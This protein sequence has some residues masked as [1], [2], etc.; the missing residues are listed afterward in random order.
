MKHLLSLSLLFAAVSL[1]AGESAPTEMQLFEYVSWEDLVSQSARKTIA[2]ALDTDAARAAY[3]ELLKE[4]RALE[5]QLEEAGIPFDRAGAVRFYMSGV[6][7][8]DPQVYSEL[9]KRIE[10]M[11]KKM[12]PDLPPGRFPDAGQREKRT[13]FLASVQ[14]DWDWLEAHSAFP[15]KAPWNTE[16]MLVSQHFRDVSLNRTLVHIWKMRIQEKAAS[17]DVS[18]ALEDFRKSRVMMDLDGFLISGLLAVSC[19][20]VRLTALSELLSRTELTPEQLEKL[21]AEL[22]EEEALL[23]R[24]WLRAWIQESACG[25]D[26]IESFIQGTVE[27]LAKYRTSEGRMP[28]LFAIPWTREW[29]FLAKRNLRIIDKVRQQEDFRPFAPDEFPKYFLLSR[30]MLDFDFDGANAI[31]FN[32]IAQIRAARTALRH[33]GLKSAEIP[34]DPFTGEPFHVREGE[35]RE[36]GHMVRGIRFYSAGRDGKYSDGTCMKS[37]LGGRKTDDRGFDLV[38]AEVPD[39]PENGDNASLSGGSQK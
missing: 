14:E 34:K 15:V 27:G 23:R 32:G 9:E 37:D 12:S 31:L 35:F 1:F 18:G 30:P 20:Y 38:E 33:L 13:K 22:Q 24:V 28:L 21:D 5:K 11:A 25:L 3:A 17:G 8:A 7:A 2:D 29:I 19:E 36:S 26:I 16:T 10:S 6:K 39:R 4:R